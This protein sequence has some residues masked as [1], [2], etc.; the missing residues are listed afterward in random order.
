MTNIF[1]LSGIAMGVSTV[2]V[3]RQTQ[4][5][6]CEK[7]TNQKNAPYRRAQHIHYNISGFDCQ[8]FLDD[9]AIF[10]PL[11]QKLFV[12]FVQFGY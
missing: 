7:T 3:G 2:N 5:R 6:E 10:L 9:N 12:N 4:S 11:V 1:G 8:A